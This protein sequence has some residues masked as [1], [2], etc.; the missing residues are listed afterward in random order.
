MVKVSVIMPHY[1]DLGGLR[2]CLAA[3][4]AQTYPRE[5][6]EIVVGDN[7]S[8][9]GPEKVAEAI[10]GRARLVTVTER[11]AGPARNG[12]V[13]A[14]SGEIL[15]FTDSDC[16]PEPQWLAAGLKALEHHDF[17]GGRVEVLVDDPARPSAAEAF[18]RVFAF[19]FE[20]YILRK[21][22]TGSGNM[23]VPRALFDR[24]GGFRT[25]VSEDAEWSFRAR[26][27]GLRLGY[28]RDAVVGHPARRSWS[29]LRA[30]GLRINSETYQLMLG[31]PNGRARWLARSL[32]MPLS[33]V[34]HTP[35]VLRSPK[36]PN[37]AARLGAL[38]MLYRLR[39]WRLLDGHALFF[40]LRK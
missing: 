39:L 23:F 4:D 18:E 16:V 40:G 6:F 21:G 15:A 26:A 28:A 5:D 30:K 9:S 10:A 29:E 7:A 12:A 24:V 1:E 11:G 20:D 27:M 22:F 13:A 3:L 38:A 32:A 36:L 17:V 19:N 33:A 34:A 25:G 31:Q 37:A 35:R 2:K 14:S 8:P